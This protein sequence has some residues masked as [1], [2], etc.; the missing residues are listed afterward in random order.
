MKFSTGLSNSIKA[1]SLVMALMLSICCSN[2]FADSC[3]KANTTTS[4]VKAT[5]PS[6]RS[7]HSATSFAPLG[8]A[9]AQSM[10]SIAQQNQSTDFTGSKTRRLSATNLPSDYGSAAR[11]PGQ[12]NSSANSTIF[13]FQNLRRTNPTNS[14]PFYE[15]AISKTVQSFSASERPKNSMTSVKL[16]ETNLKISQTGQSK[17]LFIRAFNESEVGGMSA[18]WRKLELSWRASL[19]FSTNAPATFAA[20]SMARSFALEL[21]RPPLNAS[22]HSNPATSLC[23][24]MN[25]IWVRR[26]QETPSTS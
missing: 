11:T 21:R 14:N 15:N 13:T 3:A 9:Q 5:L 16:P 10:Q 20:N 18:Q 24:C 1:A 17:Q 4:K 6:E 8:R 26:F 7:A 2:V 12:S 23:R 19:P 25:R 22:T